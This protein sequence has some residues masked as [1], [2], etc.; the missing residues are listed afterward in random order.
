MAMVEGV[1]DVEVMQGTGVWR[2]P[3]WVFQQ[4]LNAGNAPRNTMQAKE[5]TGQGGGDAQAMAAG[6]CAG[7]CRDKSF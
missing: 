7:V 1:C 6:L 3:V 4:F 2:A 5:M